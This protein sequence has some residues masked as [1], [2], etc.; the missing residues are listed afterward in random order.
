MLS[1]RNK[2]YGLPKRILQSSAQSLLSTAPNAF[3]LLPM[4][5]AR[6]FENTGKRCA[7]AHVLIRLWQLIDHRLRHVRGFVL[8]HCLETFFLDPTFDVWRDAE[9]ITLLDW[10]SG[11]LCETLSGVVL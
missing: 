1:T 11:E 9:A 10:I 7:K 8:A 4:I 6:T 3:D 2:T 5:L